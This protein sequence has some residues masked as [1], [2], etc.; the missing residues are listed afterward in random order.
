[1]RFLERFGMLC[2]ALAVTSCVSTHPRGTEV[3]IPPERISQ[4]GYSVLPLNEEGWVINRR[5]SYQLVLGK[6][7]KNPDETFSLWA[8]LARLPAFK[9][10]EEFVRIAK[11]G[12]AKDTD[13]QR[14]KTMKH[15][16]TVYPM[17]G[18][19]C[20]KSHMV[21]VDHAATKR[22]GKAGDM[23][24]E[25]LTLI[26]AH[27]KDKSVGVNVAYSHRY[28]PEFPDPKFLEKAT[29]VLDSVQ[30]TEP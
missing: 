4:K 7:G 20:A 14:F 26:C 17:K 11:E 9:T 18:V 13:P 22:S 30:I 29:S 19:D 3:R 15:E 12:Q 24:L 10:S 16:V 5:D 27:P 21:V 6:Y 28:Y 8:V 2:V 23:I 25:T 1:M